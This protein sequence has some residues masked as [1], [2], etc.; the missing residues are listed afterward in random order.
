MSRGILIYSER[1]V[2][3]Q[4]KVGFDLVPFSKQTTEYN[5]SLSYMENMEGMIYDILER[6]FVF[7]NETVAI[8]IFCIKAFKA[9][10]EDNK[11]NQNSQNSQKT[12][13]KWKPHGKNMNRRIRHQGQNNLSVI[14]VKPEEI[15]KQTKQTNANSEVDSESKK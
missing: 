1:L 5:N 11:D 3:D 12:I 2:G 10:A 14:P 15:L 4:I 13:Q 8:P 6:G 9:Q 7:I